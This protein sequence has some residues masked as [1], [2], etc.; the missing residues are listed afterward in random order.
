MPRHPVERL[1]DAVAGFTSWPD[2]VAK[3]ER[4]LS[5]FAFFPGGCGLPGIGTDGELPPIA[6]GGVLVLGHNFYSVKGFEDQQDKG[7]DDWSYATGRNLR[8]MLDAAGIPTERCFFTNFFMGLMKEEK[9][10]GTFPG[11]KEPAFVQQCLALFRLQLESIRPTSVLVLGGHVPRHLADLAEPLRGWKRC[12]TFADIDRPGLGLI[13]AVP[14]AGGTYTFAVLTHPSC[15]NAN[16]HRRRLS[17][18][19][20]EELNG[21]DAEREILRVVRNKM[22]PT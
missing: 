8:A 18:V 22:L 21:E 4:P 12:R 3:V 6:P 20:G 10:V 16:V 17:R 11:A 9:T 13:E 7:N 5:Q 19:G 15:R 1:R 2:D 14:V